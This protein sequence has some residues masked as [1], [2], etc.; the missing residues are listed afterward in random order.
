VGSIDAWRSP[1]DWE[2][3]PLEPTVNKAANDSADSRPDRAADRRRI[4]TPPKSITDRLTA[5]IARP[6]GG[7]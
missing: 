4:S 3:Q 5:G 2:A 6:A 7:N 1:D